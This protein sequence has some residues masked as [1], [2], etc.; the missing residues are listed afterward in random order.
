MQEPPRTCRTAG[1]PL[2]QLQSLA[3]QRGQIRVFHLFHP[4]RAVSLFHL[5]VQF[6]PLHPSEPSHRWPCKALAV[7]LRKK[8]QKQNARR[9]RG[10]GGRDFPS[11]S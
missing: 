1:N 9:G 2:N 4:F 11:G 6:A 3:F 5:F 10:P 7:I 8:V